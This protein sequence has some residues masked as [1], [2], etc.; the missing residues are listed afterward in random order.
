MNLFEK[1]NSVHTV[2]YALVG[3][4]EATLCHFLSLNHCP[5]LLYSGNNGDLAFALSISTIYTVIN[6]YVLTLKMNLFIL[7]KVFTLYTVKGILTSK[8]LKK[9]IYFW[10]QY[11]IKCEYWYQM[12]RFI[13]EVS[14]IWWQWYIYIVYIIFVGFECNHNVMMT[15]V[16]RDCGIN[17]D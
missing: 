3:D 12:H 16:I 5:L 17:L 10:S 15:N 13:C 8:K 1:W 6:A 9:N 14:K 2:S 7:Y 4:T 11:C